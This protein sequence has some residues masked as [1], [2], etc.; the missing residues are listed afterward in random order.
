M[1]RQL[2]IIFILLAEIFVLAH[3]SIPYLH[4]PSFEVTEN[5]E[6]EIWRQLHA[7]SVADADLENI[8][9]EAHATS[10]IRQNVNEEFVDIEFLLFIQSWNDLVLPSA[11]SFSKLEAFKEVSADLINVPYLPHEF[12][13]GPPLV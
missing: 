11:E 12:L 8:V 5:Q 6:N 4:E 3:R 10:L 13:R 9:H 2:A 7:E 1:R